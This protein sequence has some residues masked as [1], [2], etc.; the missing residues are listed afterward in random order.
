MLVATML[1]PTLF[2][3]ADT[4]LTKLVGQSANVIANP[5][6]AGALGVLISGLDDTAALILPVLGAFAVA[7]LAAG[8]AQ[9]G[10]VLSLHAAAPKWSKVN[11]IK[12]FK[13]LLSTQ[14]VWQLGKQLIKLLAL[15]GLAYGTISGLSHTLVGS[16]PTQ[17]APL[18]SYAGS[19]LLGLTRE[20]S[21]IGLV[22]GIADF[23]WQRHQLN[24]SLK[25]TKQEV[26]D[27]SKDS[28]GNPTIK[29]QIR[30]KMRGMSRAR[31]MAA[32]AGADV[33]VV[34]PTHYAVALRYDPQRGSAPIV[35]A[36]GTDEVAFRIRTEG[37]AHNVPVIEDP[38]LARAVHATCEIDDAIPPEL[39]LAV[40]RLLAFV[41][42][43]PPVVRSAGLVHRRPSSAMVA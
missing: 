34:N 7:G 13:N 38:P 25:M 16:Q 31:M 40:A 20:V 27:E 26:K 42:T 10:G 1:I 19:T 15:V 11:P 41:F 12:G 28:E 9:T 8:V 36:K 2:R 4:R 29:G 37:I 33:I 30:R 32:V 6:S 39:F 17:M 14:S 5:S 24:K 21:G 43:L 22:L 18:I 35:V 3:S 23:A